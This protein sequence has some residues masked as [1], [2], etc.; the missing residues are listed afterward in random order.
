MPSPNLAANVPAVESVLRTFRFKTYTDLATTRTIL[1][2]QIRL[3]MQHPEAYQIPIDQLCPELSSGQ[4]PAQF[5]HP[6]NIAA[7]LMNVCVS[8]LRF[9][10]DNLAPQ[11]DLQVYVGEWTRLQDC[12]FP[13]AVLAKHEDPKPKLP[14]ATAS[15][16]VQSTLAGDDSSTGGEPLQPELLGADGLPNPSIHA[17]RTGQTGRPQKSPFTKQLRERS[18]VGAEPFWMAHLRVS[19]KRIFTRSPAA[20]VD[21]SSDGVGPVQTYM[22]LVQLLQI[23][24]ADVPGHVT[25]AQLKHYLATIDAQVAG[26]QDAKAANQLRRALFSK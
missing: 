4:V 19:L 16:V 25:A 11:E 7:A 9:G 17:E 22:A 21:P 23:A 8:G 20:A 12:T 18:K 5:V 13:S 3:S 10:G 1:G 26:I 6:W 24:L 14:V 2:E 15:E